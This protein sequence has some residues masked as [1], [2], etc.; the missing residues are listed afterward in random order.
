MAKAVKEPGKKTSP[1]VWLGLV[2][3]A[4]AIYIVTTPSDTP[5]PTSSAKKKKAAAKTDGQITQADYNAY[6]KPFPPVG[7]SAVDA[8]NPLV[9]QA[10]KETPVKAIDSP[11]EGTHGVPSSLTGGE[12]NWYVT[13]VPSLNGVREALLENTATG[14][15]QYVRTGDRWKA[16]RVT[17]IDLTTLS[18]VGPT[19]ASIQ[20]PVIQPGEIPG[21][22]KTPVASNVPLTIPS[23][24]ISGAIGGAP[25]AGPRTLTLSNGQT[26][27]LPLPDASG[28]TAAPDPRTRRRNRNPNGGNSNNAQ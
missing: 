6:K 17:G 14:Q 21:G 20:V 9:K 24:G 4:V 1:V 26:L 2:A 28:T 27:Q 13:G 16:S 8:F 5:P 11:S 23:G 10:V 12:E 15:M 3:A 25:V 22:T 19:G 7:I 18:L